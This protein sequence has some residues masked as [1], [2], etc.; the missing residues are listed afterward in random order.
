MEGNQIKNFDELA[1][2][3]NRKMA[4]EIIKSGLDAINTTK[5]V[6]SSV[7]VIGNILFIKGKPFNLAKYERIKVV[8]H[9]QSIVHSLVEFVQKTVIEQLGLPDMKV[10][11]Q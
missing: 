7:S 11:I 10:P 9:P 2:T 3:P 8:I 5:V 4:L 6:D 1:T